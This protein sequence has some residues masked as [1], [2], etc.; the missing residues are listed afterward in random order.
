MFIKFVDKLLRDTMK[1]DQSNRKDISALLSVAK[2]PQTGSGFG[3]A[4]VIAESTT[5]V[6]AGTDSFSTPMLQRIIEQ[7][8]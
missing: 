6:V 3:P 4:E 7:V 2:D 1:L 5:L 8:G